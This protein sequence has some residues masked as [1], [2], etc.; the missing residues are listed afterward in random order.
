VRESRA[1]RNPFNGIERRIT[2]R[3]EPTETGKTGIHSMELKGLDAEL[4]MLYPGLL[5]IHSMELK[6]AF[7]VA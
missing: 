3:A 6:E 4:G 7:E 2:I 5:R 1:Y